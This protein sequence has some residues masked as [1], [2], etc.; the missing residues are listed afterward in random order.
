M[1]ALDGAVEPA[2]VSADERATPAILAGGPLAT[3][4]VGVCF[5]EKRV[6]SG[7][8]LSFQSRSVHAVIGP[9][10]CGKTTLLRTLNRLVELSPAARIEGTVLLGGADLL[11]QPAHDVRRRIGMVFQRPNPFPFSIFDNVA[12]A[13]RDQGSKRPR[14]RSLAEP[15]EVALRRAGLWDEI[16]DDLGRSALRLS[17]GQQQRLCI[18]R[19][20]AATPDVML[21]DEPCSSLDPASTASVED[22]IASLKQELTVVVVTHNLAQAARVSDRVAFLLGGELVEEGDTEAVFRRPSRE[23]TADYIPD[24]TGRRNTGLLE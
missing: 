21:M 10:G 4:G 17:G 7:I 23:E 22:L 12:Y 14:R 24:S 1:E 11:L 3:R 8:S 16:K 6:L 13:L 2:H 19:V 5:G 18:A 9:S 15:V 20:L